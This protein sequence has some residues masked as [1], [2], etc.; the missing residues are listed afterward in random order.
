MRTFILASLALAV[1][2]P[3]IA[4]GETGT[5]YDDMLKSE[6]HA[7]TIRSLA[8]LMLALPHERETVIPQLEQYAWFNQ[9]DAGLTKSVKELEEA[10]LTKQLDSV[11]KLVEKYGIRRFALAGFTSVGTIENLDLY[12]AANTAQGPVVVRISIYFAEEG[13]RLFGF[14]VFEG[15]QEVRTATAGIEHR[16]GQAVVAVTYT[17]ADKAKEDS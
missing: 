14:E 2:M 12:F 10:R 1:V 6:A 13:P 8:M 4:A 3:G 5:R 9:T 7:Q 15:W 17:P 11:E 16:P